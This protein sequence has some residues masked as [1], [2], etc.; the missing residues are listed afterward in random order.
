[1]AKLETIKPLIKT[2]FETAK[3]ENDVF[4]CIYFSRKEDSY[5]GHFTEN[6]DAGD[7]LI[8]IGQLLDQFK[9]NREI[10]AKM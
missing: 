5:I 7:A 6:M 1:M 2:I 9:I 4:F 3:Q 8:V 10:L